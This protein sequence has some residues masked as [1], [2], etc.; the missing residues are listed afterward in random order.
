MQ[1][2]PKIIKVSELFDG[3]KDSGENGIVGYG[4]KLNIRPAYQREFIYKADQMHAVIDTISKK[5][6]LNVM[7]WSKVSDSEWA[8]MDGQQRTISICKYCDGDFSAKVNGS[9]QFIH[10]LKSN[11]PEKYKDIMDYELLIYECIGERSEILDWFKT[12]NIAGLKLTDQ[13]LRNISYT[14]PWLTDAKKYFSKTGGP[15]SELGGGYINGTAN[16]QELLETAIKWKIKSEETKTIEEY[17]AKHMKDSDSIPLQQYFEDVIDWIERIF[18]NYRKEMKGI[19]WNDLYIECKDKS[20][21]PD[22]LEELV[23]KLMKDEDVQS[24]SGIYPYLLTGNEKWLNLRAFSDSTKSTVYERQNKKCLA[25]KK[26][27]EIEKMEADHITPWSKGGKT[28]INNCQMLCKV[29]N[30]SKSD[31]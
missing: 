27:F 21:E 28:E 29:C 13:E 16:R 7:Y 24:K 25:C 18:K 17:M 2:T 6:P 30:R 22:K 3:Y 31:K 12:I 4:G 5:F 10:N 15:A 20:F 14:G 8:L 23:T 11:L 19:E 9:F 26:E 1:I